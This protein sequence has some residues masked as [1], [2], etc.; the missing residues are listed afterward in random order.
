[1]P[2][3]L[4]IRP[5]DVL[6]LVLALLA[7]ATSSVRASWWL[8]QKRFKDDAL[9]DVGTLGLDDAHGQIVAWAYHNDDRYVDALLV[10]ADRQ[11][12]RVHEW[13]H[14]KFQFNSTPA[15]QVRVPDNMRIVN[16]VPADLNYD[17]RTDWLVMT[18]STQA[19]EAPLSLF[20][21][22]SQTD[23]QLGLPITLPASDAPHPLLVDASGTL[24]GE[25][26][27]HATAKPGTLTLWRRD[28]A[29]S[30]YSLEELT[31]HGD[32]SPCQLA[33][34][35]SSA[36]VDMNGDCLADLFLVCQG[37]LSSR[38]SYQIWTARIDEPRTYDLARAGD[39]PPGTGALSFA[40]MNR[41][42]TMDVVFPTCERGRCML[43]IAYNEQ[44]PL[45]EREK[46]GMI[47]WPNMTT[48]PDRCR[49]ELQ[50]CEAD[51]QFR[52]DFSVEEANT[53]LARLPLDTL[54]GDAS[55]LLQDD[56]GSHS[57]PVPIRIGDY[58]MDGYPD[59]ALLTVPPRAAPGRT[60]VHLL[61]STVCPKRG[62][63]GCAAGAEVEHRTFVRV[64]GTVLDTMEYVRSV[65][66]LDLDEDG[67]LDLVLQSIEPLASRTSDARSVSFV[68]NNYFHD[69]F[70]LKTLTLNAACGARCEPT[71]AKAYAPWGSALG[72]A[73]YKF[74]VLDPNGV[75]RAQQVGQQPQ[76]GYAALLSPSAFFGLGRTN[77]YVESLFV[78]STRRQVPPYLVL[79]GV[80]PNSEVVVIPTG[81]A[82]EFW[83]RE[84]FLHPAD[85]IPFVTLTLCALI[86]LLSGI[87]FMLDQREKREDERERLRAVHAINF[88]AL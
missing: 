30:Q 27:G 32:I 14:T 25:L 19:G 3:G 46:R 52:L 38:L 78:G 80:V 67:T 4:C 74:S 63:V 2:H 86:A 60:R 81:S 41:D 7:I 12:V 40:D 33:H 66:F 43:N 56:I 70:F 23:G 39:L 79:E 75:R 6:V 59:V 28:E 71:D 48:P 1:M 44:M 73:S 76:T 68:Q 36:H 31:M 5:R 50:L 58:N 47:T 62:A 21:W 26:L 69:A 85:W 45:C 9:I 87:V 35:H 29:T 83:R 84:L 17:G 42:G 54:T 77:N 13:M 55:L 53:L 82:P 61:E 15:A 20:L 11:T 65:S 10:D 8:P 18:E 51:P 57:V 64:N 34:P 16:V 49:D 88:D 24:Q 72:G 22:P 37:P